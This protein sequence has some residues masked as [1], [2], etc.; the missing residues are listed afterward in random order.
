MA[1]PLFLSF[2]GVDEDDS[3]ARFYFFHSAALTKLEKGELLLPPLPCSHW[4]L[5]VV[6]IEI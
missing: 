1:A 5:T 2:F 4:A 6:F 3:C